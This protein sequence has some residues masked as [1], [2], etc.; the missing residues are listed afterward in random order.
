M[1][2]CE[3]VRFSSVVIKKVYSLSL[4]LRGCG[5]WERKSVRSECALVASSGVRTCESGGLSSL[6]TLRFA[7][8]LAREERLQACLSNEL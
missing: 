6:Y 5:G 3:N 2:S 8:P 7:L 1:C 4:P